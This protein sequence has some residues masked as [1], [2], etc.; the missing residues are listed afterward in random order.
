MCI[1]Y[2]KRTICHGR[3]WSRG[4]V[5]GVFSQWWRHVMNWSQPPSLSPCATGEEEGEKIR[6]EVEHRKKRGVGEKCGFKFWLYFS[7]SCSDI[8]GNKL[9]LFFPKFRFFLLVTVSGEWSLLV[10]IP[11]HE[12]SLLFFCPPSSQRG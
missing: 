5:G 8:I 10:L 2:M 6:S 4:E 1:S 9:N 12:P 11:T 7:L 3:D